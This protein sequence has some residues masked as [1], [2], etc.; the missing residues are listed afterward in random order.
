[1][2]CL[3]LEMEKRRYAVVAVQLLV[4]R[5]NPR[6]WFSPTITRRQEEL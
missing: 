3:H 6:T 4:A 2:R 1:M 5:K